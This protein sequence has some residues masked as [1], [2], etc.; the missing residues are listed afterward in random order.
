MSTKYLC[1]SYLQTEYKK[2]NLTAYCDKDIEI[3]A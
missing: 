3:N 2:I 1:Y